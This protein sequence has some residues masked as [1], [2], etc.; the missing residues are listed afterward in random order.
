MIAIVDYGMGNLFSIYNALNRVDASLKIVNDP[1]DLSL[2]NADGIVI[3]GVGAF[4]RCMDRLSRFEGALLQAFLEGTP[5]L[6]I[7]IGLQVLFEQSEESPGFKGLGWIKGNVVRIP[8]GVMIPQMGWNSLSIIRP[9][10]MLEGISDGDMF[11]FVHSYYGVPTDKSV[12]SAT[13]HHGVE[14]TAAI[15]KDNLFATQ[16]H[17]EKSGVKG[18][19]ILENFV[20]STRC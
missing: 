17:P 6:G 7:C 18:L 13:T 16:F 4:G 5:I 10:E 19:K 2:A 11:Y 14:V 20:R 12:V 8:E 9:V 15:V 1:E 3:P